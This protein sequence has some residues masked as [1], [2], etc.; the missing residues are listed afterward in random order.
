MVFL[1]WMF[2][3]FGALCFIFT[4][5]FYKFAY[6]VWQRAGIKYRLAYYL[7]ES[8]FIASTSV[9]SDCCFIWIFALIIVQFSEYLMINI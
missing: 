6:F 1:Y 7:Y 4:Y 2:Q 9:R 5:K 3:I 8:E